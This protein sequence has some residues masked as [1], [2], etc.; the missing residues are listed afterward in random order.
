MSVYLDY[1]ASAPID[2]RVLDIMINVYKN[3]YGNPDS[4]THTFGDDARKVVEKARSQAAS[5]IGVR[6]DEMFFTSGATESNNIVLQGLKEYAKKS[7]K[8]HIIVSS[9]EHKAVLNTAKS[10]GSEG[11]FVDI[12]NPDE[13]GKVSVQDVIERVNESTLL[14]A[15]QHVNNET[16]IIQPVKEIGDVLKE[17]DVLFHIDA[18][19]SCG[20]LVDEVKVLNYSTLAFS[21]HKF[22]GPQGVGGL[23]MRKKKYRLPP[24][25]PIMFGG[26]QERGIRPG[27]VPVAL[28]AGLGA[29]AE[30]AE[31]EHEENSILCKEIKKMLIDILNESG[32]AY[33]FNGDQKYCV[34]STMNICIDGVSSEAL[35]LSTKKYCG[36]SNGSACNSNS[37]D[38]SYVLKAMGLSEDRIDSSIRI[39]WGPHMDVEELKM[40]F[41]DFISVAKSMA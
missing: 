5:L 37:Y 12:V 19:Q 24:I 36:I 34:S 27:T 14:V 31:R 39:S 41:S 8:N 28:T 25:N 33:V 15:I 4:R 17:K 40:D 11:F 18:T 23:I 10:M 22:S 16:G 20:K 7:G 9:I 1:N 32:I 2:D 21:A 13:T 35:M 6:N 3:E 26:P 30:F 29:A 38:P